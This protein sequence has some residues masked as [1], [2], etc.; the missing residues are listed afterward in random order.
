M[1]VR[2]KGPDQ[3]VLSPV[4][5]GSLPANGQR[6]QLRV[7]NRSTQA[8]VRFQFVL[9]P[10]NPS[11]K[12]LSPSYLSFWSL[13]PRYSDCSLRFLQLCKRLFGM[14]S[15]KVTD[16]GRKCST[17]FSFHSTTGQAGYPRSVQPSFAGRY[18]GTCPFH[19]QQTTNRATQP[20]L[21]P[22]LQSIC[23]TF[24]KAPEI[25]GGPS[26]SHGDKWN[27]GPYIAPCHL[28]MTAPRFSYP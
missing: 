10:C 1:G 2:S 17:V 3:P 14:I 15:T 12:S 27:H 11:L 24:T 21:T 5:S 23:T 25:F 9:C 22:P 20:N 28:A 7:C 26:L 18:T 6:S 19:E 16:L 13:L 4:R 8:A